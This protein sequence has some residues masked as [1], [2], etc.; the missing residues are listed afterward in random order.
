MDAPR[1][2][3]A[4]SVEY[5]APTEDNR[6]IWTV[7]A[8]A[9]ISRLLAPRAGLELG[10]NLTA[11]LARGH[12]VQLDESLNPYRLESAAAGIGPTVVLRVQP[13]RVGRVRAGAELSAG[14][15]FYSVGFPAGG[16][17]YNG[18]L[19]LGPSLAYAVNDR[20]AITL[21][22]RW[23]HVSNGRGLVPNNPSYEAQ[24]VTLGLRHA[25]GVAQRGAARSAAQRRRNIVLGAALGGVAGAALSRHC[26]ADGCRVSPG[27]TL[28][29]TW[30][31]G[32]AG[33]FLP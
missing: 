8:D 24:G 1:Q 26:P 28:A 5:L 3:R 21:A 14:V 9:G 10:L 11:S 7:T 19:R 12:I 6:R 29:A 15:L 17:R 32:T 30:V 18:M 22:A 16:E 33:G 20:T 2:S 13:L 23:M 4:V 31:G 27:I 25:Y